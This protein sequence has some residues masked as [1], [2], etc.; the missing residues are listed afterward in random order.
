MKCNFIKFV[1]SAVLMM[2]CAVMALASDLPNNV[3]YYETTNGKLIGN[4]FNY[5]V[6]D[7]LCGSKIKRHY[8]YDDGR[9]Y[10]EFESDIKVIDKDD[11]NNEDRITKIVLPESVTEI[12]DK[13]FN[14]CDGLVTVN[15]GN[16]V[17]KIG[18]C[19]FYHCDN[20]KN[21]TLSNSLESIGGHD[22]T[23]GVFEECDELETIFIPASVTLLYRNAFYDCNKLEFVAIGS[24]VTSI[25]EQTFY[26]CEKLKHVII[27]GNGVSIGEKS[28]CGC[29]ELETVSFLGNTPPSSFGEKCFDECGTNLKYHVLEEYY[30]KYNG[31]ISSYLHGKVVAGPP[32]NEIWYTTNNRAAAGYVKSNA[33]KMNMYLGNHG[34]QFYNSSNLGNLLEFSSNG[35]CFKDCSNL[36]SAVLPTTITVIGTEAFCNC[37]NLVSVVLP[38]TITGIGDK[39][40]YNCGNLVSVSIPSMVQKIG[41]SAFDRCVNLRNIKLPDNLESINELAFWDCE[42][43][44]SITIPKKV[45]VIPN[46]AFEKCKNLLSVIIS[47]NIESIGNSAFNGNGK[48]IEIFYLGDKSPDLGTNALNNCPAT[49]YMKDAAGHSDWG[50]N[51]VLS[52]RSGKGDGSA[53]SPLEIESYLQLYGF[54]LEV[55]YMNGAN[56]CAKLTR[57]ITANTDVL[58]EDG[59]LRPGTF[60]HWLPIGSWDNNYI[61]SYTG[62]FDGDGHTISGLYFNDESRSA[63]G[64]FG[65]ANGTSTYRARIHDVGV[66]DSYF[67][68]NT[69]VGGI[70]GD[71]A[72][73]QMWNCWNAATVQ[74]KSGV[75]GGMAGS[76]Y[77]S[78]FI[79]GCYNIGKVYGTGEY[80]GI[81]GAVASSNIADHS[82]SNCVSL[83]TK[84]IKAYTLATGC[85]ESK[86]SNVFI[87]DANAFASGEV[88]WILNGYQP[89]DHWRQKLMQ[90]SYPTLTGDYFVYKKTNTNEYYNS[91]DDNR[92]SGSGTQDDPYRIGNCFELLRFADIVNTQNRAACGILTTDI[93]M[94]TGVLDSDGNLNSG[95]IF[96][97]WTPIGGEGYG[98]QGEFD[99]AG[100][101]ISG[102]YINDASMDCAALFGKIV[103]SANI[104]DLGVQDSYFRGNIWVA[105]ICGDFAGGT[106]ENCWN[107]AT[108]I[109]CHSSPTAGGIA[110]SCW[111]NASVSGCFNIGKISVESNNKNLC[112]GICGIVAKN[113]NVTY[114]VSNCVSLKDKCEKA[115]NLYTETS[116]YSG[117]TDTYAT[118]GNASVSNVSIENFSLFKSGGVCWILNGSQRSITWRQQIGKDDYPV[119]TGNYLVYAEGDRDY[120]NETMCDKATNHL[121]TFESK[122]MTYGGNTINYWHCTSCGKDYLFDYRTNELVK[123]ELIKPSTGDGSKNSPYQIATLGNLLWFANS[124]NGGNPSA[125]A[126]L[127]EDITMNTDV[128]NEDGDFNS[129]YFIDWTPI[130]GSGLEYCGEFDGNGH[131]IS[132]LY[133]KNTEVYNVGFFGKAAG[134]A[135]IHDLGIK[136]SYF[137]G[138]HHVGGICGDFASGLIENCWSGAHVRAYEYDAGGI[139]GSCWVYASIADCYNIGRVS[140]Y[141]DK[142]A[143]IKVK[144][145]GIC[146]S[147]YSTTTATYSISNCYT[148]INNDA[149]RGNALPYNDCDKIYGYLAE[150]CPESKIHDSYVKTAAAFTGGEVCYKLNH[151]VTTDGNQ[152]WYQTLESDLLP[153]LD[154]RHEV[155]LC[156][157]YDVFTNRLAYYEKREATRNAVGFTTACWEDVKECKLYA[158]ETCQNELDPATVVTYHPL[159]YNPV[160]NTNL[161]SKKGS[162]MYYKYDGVQYQLDWAADTR[163]E[164]SDVGKRNVEFSVEGTDVR[165]ARIKWFKQPESSYARQGEFTINV[166]VNDERVYTCQESRN[167][168]KYHDGLYEVYL[169]D[170]KHG[171]VVKFEVDRPERLE[172]YFVDYSVV[173]KFFVTI[174]ACLEYTRTKDCGVITVKVGDNAKIKGGADPELKWDDSDLSGEFDRNNIILTRDAGEEPGEYT[175]R[176]SLS[177]DADCDCEIISINGK[178]TIVNGTHHE[179]VEPT[180]RKTGNMKYWKVSS[181]GKLYKDPY[182]AME[183]NPEDVL[184]YVTLPMNPVISNNGFEIKNPAYYTA[185]QCRFDW[186]AETSYTHN[187]YGV[188]SVEF[189]VS[190]PEVGDARIRWFKKIP[191]YPSGD[192]TTNIYVNGI[193]VYQYK[194]KEGGEGIT[195]VPLKELKKGDVVKFEIQRWGGTSARYTYAACLEYTRAADGIT[196]QADDSWKVSGRSDPELTWHIAYYFGDDI[197][198]EDKDISITRVAGE[199]PGEYAIHASLAEG[200]ESNYDITF[201]DGKFTISDVIHHLKS[202]DGPTINTRSFSQDCYEVTYTGQL[203]GQYDSQNGVVLEN[204]LNP[205]SVVTYYK[206]LMCPV[207]S[208]N[209]FDISEN[210]TYNDVTFNWAAATTYETS[211][212]TGTRS[213]E[214]KVRGADIGTARI[215]WFKD[216]YD[217]DY[218]HFTINVYVNNNKV[219][220]R[221]DDGTMGGLFAISLNGLKQNDVIRFETQ[222]PYNSTVN[223][224]DVTIAACLEYTRENEGTITVG[225]DD[226]TKIKDLEDPELTYK[227]SDVLS[228]DFNKDNII[229]T[230]GDGEALGEYTIRASL[231]DK[232]NCKYGINSIDGKLTIIE[233]THY[234]KVEPTISTVGNMEYWKVT[235]TGKLYCDPYLANELSPVSIIT[236]RKL[237]QNPVSSLNDFVSKTKT[238]YYDNCQFDWAVEADFASRVLS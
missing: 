144:Y 149:G 227:I 9:C 180:I 32:Y 238:A 107:G 70:C 94:N 148:L 26:H 40:F 152:K 202:A 158:D 128:L 185:K 38:T 58:N 126:I 71:L 175:I 75:V 31:N 138:K 141:Q 65:M 182:F 222:K 130:G 93:T 85:P 210:A 12:K 153:V 179:E 123:T 125:C 89:S 186:A 190:G 73:G 177:E 74:A 209:G 161:F 60:K 145:G 68:G 214:F 20:L 59:T 111:K 23:Y 79:S 24:G 162:V 56:L 11:F 131:T 90:N 143:E 194:E 183:L 51:P 53:A 154:N 63:V 215:K 34:V 101:T 67:Y 151:G 212:S 22:D 233:G 167:E 205:A 113:T 173:D 35:S 208:T 228:D 168:G 124:V 14:D 216:S 224:G 84:C 48:L 54:S 95:R 110:G 1:F 225:V 118:I 120:H 27:D 21:I 102:L 109:G 115:Y 119:R 133:F 91:D 122:N 213:V 135:Y 69:H 199:E 169:P 43:L 139:S 136:D 33:P 211:N 41:T 106:I 88:C 78:A 156:S 192:I 72:K 171:D 219:Y 4:V 204:E 127:T 142:D 195:T 6:G 155:V 198:I 99:G 134:G 87:K 13:A 100:H 36:V 157:K 159:I 55:N 193:N 25:P 103:N 129:E 17:K 108:V 201:V 181:T 83:D 98:Y 82:L 97:T 132:G 166:Y 237:T 197:P 42:S 217:T 112:G 229:I 28:F 196:V 117:L 8:Y 66:K 188:R 187:D 92:I 45:S 174:A 236:Y 150:N 52:W 61:G 203:Y 7:K 114:S 189:V 234:E 86:V 235:S 232:D 2:C 116:D 105:G 5:N 37:K 140:L 15:M 230:R 218:G 18:Y 57:D 164:Y 47:G 29:K 223:D 220:T 191:S 226:K 200:V 231:S 19:A 80:G 10:L 44:Q 147:V 77:Y 184:T 207:E 49:I 137:Y 50:L 46:Q 206:L 64:L 163:Y 3:I 39:A 96:E 146:G 165:S 121:H 30:E 160:K 178:F 176:A 62:D 76:C 104:H 81:C 221:T 172:H 170:L 16:N